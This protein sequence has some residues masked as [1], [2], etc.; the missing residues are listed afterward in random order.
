MVFE[1]KDW[2]YFT[3]DEM[4]CKGTGKCNMDEDF[5]RKLVRLREDYGKPMIVSSGYRDISYNTVIRGARNS[6][7]IYGKAVDI[8]CHSNQAFTI[9]RLAMMHGFTGIGV[10]QRGPVEKRFIHL[11]TMTNSQETPRPSI[12][13][14][15]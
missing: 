5:M 7:H 4:R 6:A 1:P 10:S 8:L 2:I 9:V 12:W 15:K 3:E 14:Y 13:S 11:D